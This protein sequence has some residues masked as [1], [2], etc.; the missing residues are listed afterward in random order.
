MLCLRLTAAFIAVSL[1]VVRGGAPERQTSER[2][3]ENI[4]CVV[5]FA[6]HRLPKPEWKDFRVQKHVHSPFISV[7]CFD[8][9]AFS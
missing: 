8:L 7:L 4:T 9:W 3:C 6:F 2:G 5:M 1:G